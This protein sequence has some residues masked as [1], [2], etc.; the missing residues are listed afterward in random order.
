[1]DKLTRKQYS[2]VKSWDGNRT[3]NVSLDFDYRA[4]T[5]DKIRISASG[6]A[7]V[8]PTEKVVETGIDATVLIKVTIKKPSPELVAVTFTL[9]PQH[10]SIFV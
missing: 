1:M 10:F 2:K 7:T 5:T 3:V 9:G 6:G 4:E 8:E